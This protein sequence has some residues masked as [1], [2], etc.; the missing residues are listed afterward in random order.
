MARASP[1]RLPALPSSEGGERGLVPLRNRSPPTF[2]RLDVLEDR[3]LHQ[4]KTTQSLVDRA[5]RIKE[6]LIESLS[7]TK[8]TLQGE[9][10]AR[11]LLEDHIRTITVVVKRLSREIE[12]L[13]DQIKAKES[14]IQG[15]NITAKNLEFQHVA[16]VGDLRGRV[17]RC[18]ASI[19]RLAADLR[20]VSE[21]L[22][23]VHREQANS[24]AILKN[25]LDRLEQSTS[26][27]NSNL[28]KT[29]TEQSSKLKEVE[30]QN[31]SQLALLDSKT[32]GLVE[33]IRA[34]IASNH[35]YAEGERERLEQHLLNRIELSHHTRDV[36]QAQFEKRVEDKIDK[37]AT[38][39]KKLEEEVLRQAERAKAD[40]FA[41]TTR[42]RMER[43]ERL[44]REEVEKLRAEL[45]HGFK[46][47]HHSMNSMRSVM[48]GKRELLKEELQKELTQVRK[49]VVLI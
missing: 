5:F 8:G 3:L 49:M 32:R 12:V 47:V 37:L 28:G 33:D 6:D 17:A 2:H 15:T 18:D 25:K 26:E 43:L 7:F 39:L 31:S 24:T 29:T 23:A 30:G 35:R 21:S 45:H 40:T 9:Q 38:R 42:T 34:S 10:T 19:A 1:S 36:R 41:Q 20:T 27:L 44:Q 13:E 46:D 16:G 4:E 11:Q 22:Q 14:E 48:D